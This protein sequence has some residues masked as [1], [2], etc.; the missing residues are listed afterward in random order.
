MVM[1]HDI[2]EIAISTCEDGKMAE[3]KVC[4]F[5]VTQNSSACSFWTK[6]SI[7]IYLQI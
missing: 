7:V 2:K 3:S 6:A 4:Q 5:A 1:M